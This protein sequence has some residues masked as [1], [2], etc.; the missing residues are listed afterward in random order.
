VKQQLLCAVLEFALA[1]LKNVWTFDGSC[2]EMDAA[3][4]SDDRIGFPPGYVSTPPVVSLLIQTRLQTGQRYRWGK[5]PRLF[6]IRSIQAMSKRCSKAYLL[7]ISRVLVVTENPR[8]ILTFSTSEATRNHQKGE[9]RRA[10]SC[11]VS[12]VRLIAVFSGYTVGTHGR[13]IH[14]CGRSFAR[15]AIR[16]IQSKYPPNRL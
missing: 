5:T 2:A 15:V 8:P 12:Y 14:G 4:N 7:S 9:A 10:L 6:S 11:A 13:F 16:Q 1:T 3:I